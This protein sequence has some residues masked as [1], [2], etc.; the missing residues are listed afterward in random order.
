[1]KPADLILQNGRITT[2]DTRH[3]EAKEVIIADG[4]I[5]GVDNASEFEPQP[6]T[7]VIDLKGAGSSQGFM[8]RICTSFAAD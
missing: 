7:K 2:L 8:I 4:R 1:M 3:P 5:V 6:E